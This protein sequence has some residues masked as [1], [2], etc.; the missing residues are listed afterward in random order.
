MSFINRLLQNTRKPEGFWGRFMMTGMNI[1]HA[2]L[3]NW[4]MSLLKWQPEWSV[5]DIGCG[6]GANLA[7]LMKLCPQGKV[8]GVDYSRDSV[9]FSMRH[10]RKE[11]GQRCFVEQ[12]CADSLPFAAGSFDAVTAFE[13]IYFWGDLEKCFNETARVLRPGGNFLICCEASDPSNTQW[14]DRIEGM[15]IYE[16]EELRATLSTSGFSDIRT[17]RKG[18]FFGMTAKKNLPRA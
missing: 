3:S 17:F 1:G 18:S 8:Y 9:R 16:E 14:T 10:N 11:L 7:K 15:R 6:G 2:P 12:A 13:T 5:L 4:G